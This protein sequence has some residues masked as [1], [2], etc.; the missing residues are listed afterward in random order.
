M[1]DKCPWLLLRRIRFHRSDQQRALRSTPPQAVLLAVAEREQIV[2][3]YIE[4]ISSE[5]HQQ[6]AGH[7]QTLGVARGR[8]ADQS[9]G[10]DRITHR[11]E[12]LPHCR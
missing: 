1:R 10:A 4:P 5:L 11:L 7:E 6:P 8:N 12:E 2:D 3:G 9:A